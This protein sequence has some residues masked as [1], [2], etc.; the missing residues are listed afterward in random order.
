M[1]HDLVQYS[2]ALGRR[3]YALAV[4]PASLALSLWGTGGQISLWGA[5]ELLLLGIPIAGFIAWR[6]QYRHVVALEQRG[7][8]IV[9]G[10]G[11]LRALGT[12][13]FDSPARGGRDFQ[14]WAMEYAEWSVSVLKLLTSL[15]RPRFTNPSPGQQIP[16]RMTFG[17]EHGNLQQRLGLQLLVLEDVVRARQL[18]GTPRRT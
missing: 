11:R 5:V 6:E 17:G 16:Y 4:G 18:A 1:W 3:W 13:L 15:E 9:V 7:D 12:D 14:R 10:L 2:K 8:D